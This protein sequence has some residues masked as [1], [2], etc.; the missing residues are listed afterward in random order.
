MLDAPADGDSPP[1]TQ[2]RNG[3]FIGMRFTP[4]PYETPLVLNAQIR[5]MLPRSDGNS[6]YLGLQIVGLE[7]SP[8][9][10]RVL[11]RLVSVVEQ[12]YKMN[13]PGAAKKNHSHVGAT[14]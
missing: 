7:A 10:R 6:I 3:Q 8:E 5:N 12:Y 11:S 4:L 1:D 2:F 9:G 13:R 14:A